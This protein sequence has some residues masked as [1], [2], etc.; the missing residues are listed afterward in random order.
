MLKNLKNELENS[1]R[2]AVDL[3]EIVIVFSRPPDFKLGDIATPLSF[4]LAKKLK[5]NP[6]QIAKD[7]VDTIILPEGIERAENSGGYINFFFDRKYFSKKTVMTII[8]E[9]DSYGKGEEK[10]EK[11]MVEYSQPNTHKSFHIGHLRNVCLGDAL[12]NIMEFSGYPTVKANYIGDVGAHVAKCL[13]GYMKFYN[14]VVP[15]KN[16]GEFLGKVYS[17]ADNKLKKSEDY[18]EEYKVV[19]KNLY[20]EDKRTMD[21][22]RMTREWSLEE[23][24]RIYKELGVNFDI[25][26]YESE[27]KDE[28]TKIAKELLDKGVAKNKDG[29]VIVDLKEYGL[30]EFVILRSD[31]TALYSTK[32][33]AL[34]EKKFQDFKIDLSL[35]VVGSEQKFYFKQLF[36]TL[37][38]MG[39]SQAKRCYHL[40]YE[41]VMLEEG[42]MSSREGNVVLYSE[43][44]D[45]VKKEALKQVRERNISNAESISEIVT[46][47]ALK[48]SMMKDNNKR[49]IFNWK[50]ALDFEGDTAPY[51][52]YAHARASSIL[53][54][55][56]V[57]T[58]EFEIDELNEKEYKLVSLL[59]ELPE[60]VEKASIDYRPDYVSNYVYDVAK[61]FNEFYHE[62]HVINAE[63]NKEFRASL[64]K[65]TKIVLHNA[66]ALL[67]I[68]APEEM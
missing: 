28:G 40:S 59:S 35:Y 46:L 68:K 29:A 55:I 47:G 43:L 17:E 50:K 61:C 23:F 15:E 37:E 10:K 45:V 49:I 52:Q 53:K 27:V 14:G 62:C 58:S 13:W 38:L 66:L 8:N 67:G 3:E 9:N 2:K 42:K 25:F 18:Q 4:E 32:D 57:F 41:L 21:V 19:L 34:A 20:E 63:S 39:F 12:A 48:Y 5:K 54:K 56:A 1:I 11:V 33:L 6:M 36:K 24:N 30:D 22:W 26:F 65:A 60:I 64:V 7:I 16:R 51:I 31:G 44:K